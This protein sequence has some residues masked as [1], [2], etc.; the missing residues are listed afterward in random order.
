ME[1][2]GAG[3]WVGATLLSKP[4]SPKPIKRNRAIRQ[5]VTMPI[6]KTNFDTRPLDPCRSSIIGLPAITI[7]PVRCPQTLSGNPNP[8]SLPR[9]RVEFHDEEDADRV[10]LVTA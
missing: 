1:P 6:V 3:D 10:K 4:N 8:P 9:K 7:A 2:L 5:A